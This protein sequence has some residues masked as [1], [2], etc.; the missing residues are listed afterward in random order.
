M[1]TSRLTCCFFM[2]SSCSQPH[3][4]GDMMSLTLDRRKSLV[5]KITADIAD[6]NLQLFQ[7]IE[8]DA[9]FDKLLK[10]TNSI[11][12]SGIRIS[13]VIPLSDVEEKDFF[14]L[15]AQ[16]RHNI[17]SADFEIDISNL[18]EKFEKV[19]STLVHQHIPLVSAWLNMNVAK[20]S[21]K[22]Y[23]MCKDEKK[24]EGMCVLMKCVDRFD[25]SRK[26]RFSTYL[27][28]ALNNMVFK[29]VR[30]NKK[31][32]VEIESSSLDVSS[33]H[34]RRC[35][36]SPLEIEV[37]NIWK[38]C[39]GGEGSAKFLTE[40]EKMIICVEFSDIYSGLDQESK[41]KS[42]GINI[43]TF[44]KNRKVALDKMRDALA[45]RMAF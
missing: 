13:D 45:A 1:T 6:F 12:I 27:F 43:E 24:S 19:R 10:R 37:E 33:I 18:I 15:Y 2:L 25:P 35:R 40:T 7:N 38:G 8:I 34:D 16:I 26:I 17:K 28:S 32:K 14:N 3:K 29:D 22:R 9:N 42:I 5:D 11:K 41:A 20:S 44:R 36:K 21:A 39:M 4:K 23:L 31:R 30:D